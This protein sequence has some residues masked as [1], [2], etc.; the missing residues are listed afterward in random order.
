MLRSGGVAERRVPMRLIRL[1]LFVG[2]I[3]MAMAWANRSAHAEGFFSKLFGWGSS[4]RTER[5][6]EPP[7]WNF[8]FGGG[9]QRM[10]YGRGYGDYGWPQDTARYR[11]LCVR[12][13][14][15]FYFP[16]GDNVGRERLHQDART[17]EARCY[18]EAALY[19]YPLNGGSPETMVDMRGQPY[20][21]TPT[22][23]VY[24]KKLVEGCTC[25]PAPWSAESAA[26][27]QGYKDDERAIAD[28]RRGEQRYAGGAAPTGEID[29]YLMRENDGPQQTPWQ[30]GYRRY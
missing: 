6:I 19:Y 2:G 26:R 8:G 16:I 15:G 18:G 28:M 14:D 1:C 17:C 27:H 12:T 4:K 13:C 23:F 20:A 7:T 29:A 3:V 30:G 25:K 11:T 9:G 5:T 21:Q 22:A 24:R 10:D